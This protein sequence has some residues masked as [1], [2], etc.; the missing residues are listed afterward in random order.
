M[1]YVP[2]RRSPDRRGKYDRRWSS[3]MSAD[4][5]GAEKL[6][7]NIS[8]LRRRMAGLHER[9]TPGDDPGVCLEALDRLAREGME[10]CCDGTL[11]IEDG[12]RIVSMNAA[13]EQLFCRRARDVLGREFCQAFPETRFDILAD[14]LREA[15][16]ARQSSSFITALGEPPGLQWY[17]IRAFPGDRGLE[18]HF[19]RIREIGRPQLPTPPTLNDIAR[20]TLR[21]CRSA[22]GARRGNVVLFTQGSRDREVLMLD[23]AHLPKFDDAGVR[24]PVVGLWSR[25]IRERRTAALDAAAPGIDGSRRSN[26][27]CVPLLAGN[28]VKGVLTMAEKA[29]GFSREDERVIDMFARRIAEAVTTFGQGLGRAR[30][31]LARADAAA[32]GA[33][34]ICNEDGRILDVNETACDWLGYSREDLLAMDLHALHSPRSTERIQSLLRTTRRR[35]QAEHD[36]ELVCRG[37]KLLPVRLKSTRIMRDGKV[38]IL[39]VARDERQKRAIASMRVNARRLEAASRATLTLTQ[40]L[41]AILASIAAKAERL[42][43]SPG[44][45][46]KLSEE[47]SSITMEVWRAADMASRLAAFARKKGGH[48]RLV[49]VN[50]FLSGMQE[51]LARLVSGHISLSAAF[52]PGI[53]SVL[54]DPGQLEQA[55]IELAITCREAMPRGGILQMETR[56]VRPGEPPLLLHPEANVCDYALLIL[57]CSGK[58]IRKEAL[59]RVHE[60]FFTAA[61]H[62]TSTGMGPTTIHGIVKQLGG[63]IEE[64]ASAVQGAALRVFLPITSSSTS[65][66]RAAPM[67]VSTSADFPETVLL[68]EDDEEHRSHEE[69]VLRR[70]GYTVI[71]MPHVKGISSLDDEWPSIAAA[72]FPREVSR[73]V[74]GTFHALF[75]NAGLVL[76]DRAQGPEKP[77]AGLF[78]SKLCVIRRPFSLREFAIT[79][80]EM[81]SRGPR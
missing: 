67:T 30:R 55:T 49:D 57:R 47:V 27:L 50:A 39:T 77:L 74:L 5:L 37:G 32:P 41:N 18:L 56:L 45:Q 25:A 1:I 69:A 68:V 71:S 28:E 19:S 26:A 40:D 12:M 34:I 58:G 4:F 66:E 6:L 76:V 73:R 16:A 8:D 35:G 21:A 9:S 38:A 52:G 22:V 64:E 20:S 78:S 54:V 2:E 62:A 3:K 24:D 31:F 70:C 60:S 33:V 29:N 44:L 43:S 51:R 72:V 36:A 46:E 63:F 23:P 81:A 53:G 79:V 42:R 14:E 15:L 80:W 59:G 75:P 17:E 61:A 10:S 48:P 7:E 13:A 11:I 65:N